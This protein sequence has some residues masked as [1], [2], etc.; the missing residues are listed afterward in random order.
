MEKRE[1]ESIAVLGDKERK[2]C[3]E[4]ASDIIRKTMENADG[5]LGR[6]RVATVWKSERYENVC[7]KVVSDYTAYFESNNIYEEGAFLEELGDLSVKGVR[8]PEL[9]FYLEQD[10]L[11]VLVMENLPAV[12]IKDVVFGAGLP[13]QYDEKTF[14]NDLCEYVQKMHEKGIFHRDLHFENIMIDA[15]TGK[16]FIIDFGDSIKMPE[17][18]QD[19]PYEVRD[20]YSKSVTGRKQDDFECIEEV[21]KDFSSSLKRKKQK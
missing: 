17:N 19:D 3:E 5:A 11:V 6:G 21:R 1:I 16:P 15:I 18:S 14:W 7:Y 8:T 9:Y 12:S 13:N 20:R 10:G 2:T 4:E